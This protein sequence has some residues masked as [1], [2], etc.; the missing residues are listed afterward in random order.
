[1][2]RI[3]V[4]ALVALVVSGP[5]WGADDQGVFNIIGSGNENCGTWTKLRMSGKWQQ[6]AEWSAGY[7]TANNLHTANSRGL[8][9]SD[10]DAIVS[11]LDNYCQDNPFSLWQNANEQLMLQ[12][13]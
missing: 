13:E 10:G 9:A 6:M 11:W 5:A 2:T 7:I 4:A 8:S 3:I 12:R 1:M